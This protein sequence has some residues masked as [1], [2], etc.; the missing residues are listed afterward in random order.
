MFGGPLSLK[1]IKTH[2]EL[3][4]VKGWSGRDVFDAFKMLPSGEQQMVWKLF[5]KGRQKEGCD[6]AYREQTSGA[7]GNKRKQDILTSWLLDEGKCGQ[8]YQKACFQ[9]T[10]MSSH[11]KP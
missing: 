10:K 5:E 3:L 1:N 2:S 9:L 7:G 8:Y 11:P 6:G 4:E